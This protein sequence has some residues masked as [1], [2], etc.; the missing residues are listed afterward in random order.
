MTVRTPSPIKGGIK[1][2]EKHVYQA[3]A[4]LV[5]KH[6]AILDGIRPPDFLMG[7][8]EGLNM[9]EELRLRVTQIEH[10]IQSDIA[11]YVALGVLENA[12]VK[13]AGRRARRSTAR[14]RTGER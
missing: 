12:E 14:G 8:E 13:A 3:A 1:L 6:K 11:G 5:V 9:M 4:S 2:D 10:Y 7:K